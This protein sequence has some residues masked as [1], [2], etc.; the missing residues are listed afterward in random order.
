M[1]CCSSTTNR[2]GHAAA[3][4]REARER[5]AARRCCGRCRRRSRAS[6]RR[7]RAAAG[8]GEAGRRA[9][10]VSALRGAALQADNKHSAAVRSPLGSTP[11]AAA[12]GAALLG[13]LHACDH[14]VG[15]S[16]CSVGG[17]PSVRPSCEHV[18]V[19]RRDKPEQGKGWKSPTPEGLATRGGPESCVG[20]REG[21]G[22][23]LVGVL[24]GWVIE[25]RNQGIGVPTPSRNAVGTPS[26]TLWRV[27]GGPCAVK[28]RA[29]EEALFARTGR[30]TTSS[31]GTVC[32]PCGAEAS[33]TTWAETG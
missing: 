3:V 28:T 29:C 32:G 22:E 24:I 2:R 30:S 13:R 26:A 7:E 1:R 20:V 6:C 23:A 4:W 8:S 5:D 17:R 27:A 19:K 11:G 25:P 31:R 15:R 21:V 16:R 18:F 14:G 10:A 12:V 33:A 9:R